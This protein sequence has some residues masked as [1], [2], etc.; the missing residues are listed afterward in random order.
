MTINSDGNRTS[1]S[2][3]TIRMN[4]FT[5]ANLTFLV[6]L[7]WFTNF[8]DYLKLIVHFNHYPYSSIIAENSTILAFYTIFITGF[9]I[10][11]AYIL[12][13]ILR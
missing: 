9:T 12:D 5:K 10:L 11:S 4:N 1:N 13:E 7:Y 6:V 3:L 8:S 2:Q